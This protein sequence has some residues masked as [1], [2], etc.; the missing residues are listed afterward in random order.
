MGT[1]LL[2]LAEGVDERRY[3]NR[4]E[5]AARIDSLL[6][7]A[8]DHRILLLHGPAGIGKSAALREIAR[9]AEG[10]GFAVIRLDGRRLADCLS[11]EDELAMVRPDDSAPTLV[12]VDEIDRLG[13]GLRTLGAWIAELPGTARV[14]SAAGRDRPAAGSTRACSR[15]PSPCVSLR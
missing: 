12:L 14:A 8:P 5:V 3:V 1:S 2:N 11:L 6:S 9:Q 4:E 7:L 15:W 13:A 10:S